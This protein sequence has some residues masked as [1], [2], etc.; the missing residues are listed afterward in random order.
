MT[1][2]FSKSILGKLSFNTCTPLLNQ[3][4]LWGSR[5]LTHMF[6]HVQCSPWEKEH[7]SIRKQVL[8]QHKGSIIIHNIFPPFFSTP[9]HIPPSYIYCACVIRGIT[10][11]CIL[12]IHIIW[13][14]EVGGH[15]ISWWDN[16]NINTKKKSEALDL[17]T[18]SKHSHPSTEFTNYSV[19]SIYRFSRDR[20]KWSTNTEKR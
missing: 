6:I 14:D 11:Q 5:R 7:T 2:N 19:L 16:R 20:R 17:S 3:S 15:M 18:S 13:Q 10:L 4:N 12:S 8:A 9:K 1:E